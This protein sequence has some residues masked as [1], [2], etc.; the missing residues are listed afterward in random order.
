MV[1]FLGKPEKY[2]L[3]SSQWIESINKSIVL[4]KRWHREWG[5]RVSH[6]E[7]GKVSQGEHLPER[8]DNQASEKLMALQQQLELMS[9]FGNHRRVK[10]EW[11]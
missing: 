7:R 6:E 9:K 10:T 3:D 5:D 2:A 11:D 8:G 4:N 1:R